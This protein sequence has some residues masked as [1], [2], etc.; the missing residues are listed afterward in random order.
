MVAVFGD[1]AQKE[2]L[3]LNEVIGVGALMI[4]IVLVSL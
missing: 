3:R 4:I 2:E 1:K